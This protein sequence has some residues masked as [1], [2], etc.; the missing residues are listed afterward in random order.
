MHLVGHHDKERP[1]IF[2]A[3]GD[4]HTSVP[5]FAAHTALDKGSRAPQIIMLHDGDVKTKKSR[6]Y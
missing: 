5:L 2:A 1:N 3:N 6:A 4:E